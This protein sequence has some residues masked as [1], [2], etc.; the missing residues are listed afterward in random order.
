MTKDTAQYTADDLAQI[1]AKWLERIASAEKREEAWIKDAEAAERAYLCDGANGGKDVPDF[2]ILHSNVETIVPSIYNSTPVP[3]IRPR[4]GN[5]DAAAKDAGTLLERAI[6]VQIDDSRLDAEIEKSAQDAFMAGRGV[7]RVRFDADE[8]PMGIANERLAFEV[9]PWSSYREG[10]ARRWSDVPWVAFCHFVSREE[11][12]RIEDADLTNAQPEAT[13]SKD[14]DQ[15][16]WEIWCKTSRNVY[17][18]ERDSQKVLAIKKDPLGLRGFFPMPEPIQPITGTSKRTPVCPYT[19]YKTLAEELDRQTRRINAIVAGL[20][21]R[22]AFA[23]DAAAIEAIAQAGDNEI[24]SVPNIE[25]L[26][27]AGGLEKAVMWWPIDTAIAVVRE[28]YLQRD[29]TKAAIYEITGI[30]DIIRGNGNAGETATAQQIKTQW[31]ALRIKKMQRLIER[32]VRD[33]FVIS[34]EIIARHFG[35]GTLGQMAGMEVTPEAQQL[36]QEPLNHYRINVESDSTVRADLTRGRQEMAEFLQGTAQFFQVMAPIVQQA[37]QSAGPLVEMYAAFARQFSLGKSAED[38]LEQFSEMAQQAASQPQ[39]NP[40]A[41]A[42]KAEAEAKGAELKLKEQDQQIKAMTEA[43]K[44][45]LDR[46]RLD[47]ERARFGLDAQTRQAE[48]QARSQEAA[49]QMA[50]GGDVLAG[51]VQDA[52]APILAEIQNGNTG[53]ASMIAQLGQAVLGGNEQIVA[54]MTAPKRVIKDANGR[55]VGV[56]TILN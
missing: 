48:T 37:P 45:K 33:I 56:E 55:P 15:A 12:E 36:L 46:E 2:N 35:A 42:M 38:A 49:G 7:V 34:A 39:P 51:L 50:Q 19:V 11:A 53:L 24:V 30:S 29:Q 47:L 54:A 26:V 16:I 13:V 43:E 6:S 1:G 14:D 20:K 25:N 23:A 17:F 41:D 27:A 10:P 28:L 9:V 22:G 3:D 4:H 5:K 40:Q 52:F 21:V 44:L 31:G 18:I 8:T 32:Q